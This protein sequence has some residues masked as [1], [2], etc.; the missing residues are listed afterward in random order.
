MCC[1][2]DSGMHEDELYPLLGSRI[3]TR[4]RTLKMTQRELADAVGMSRASVANIEC[5]RQKMLVHHLYRLAGALQLTSPAD[6]LPPAPSLARTSATS[7][8]EIEFSGAYISDKSKAVM[9]ELLSKAMQTTRTRT[10]KS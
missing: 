9:S 8:P 10:P 6:L 2:K 7:L 1:V 5:G 3:S 4:R